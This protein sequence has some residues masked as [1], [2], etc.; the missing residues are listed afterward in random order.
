MQKSILHLD[1]KQGQT[2]HAIFKNN[3]GRRLYIQL[4]INNNEIFISDCFYTDRPA[5]NGHNAVPCKFHTSHCTC[6]S[7]I[8][9]F[10]NELDKTF[11]GIEFS[12]TENKFSTE[13]Y[14]KLKTQVK[15]K[16]KF[17]I[18]VND[19]NT[20]KTRLKNR[21]H[22][23]ILLKIVRNG[24]KGTIIDCHYSDRTYKRNNAYI[25]PSGLTSI[26]FDFSLYNILKIVN[27][28]LNCDFTD[29]II[30]QDSFGFN[31][32]PLPICGSI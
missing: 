31:D 4:Q 9:V 14:I 30:T 11:F 22:R 19:N 6:D 13:E 3:H 24:N 28:E 1:K 20:Y 15:T 18:L 17:L 16:Y 32:S 26:T 27:S 5:R 8:D 7:L 2:Y 23:S 29:V 10:K 21:I 12:D 25:T